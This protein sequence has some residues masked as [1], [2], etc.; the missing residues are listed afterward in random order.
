MG[1]TV[2]TTPSPVMRILSTIRSTDV[3]I[4]LRVTLCEIVLTLC[5][6]GLAC[7]QPHR[8]VAESATVSA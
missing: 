1:T 3:D 8:F 5:N 6:N 2:S 7:G 4:D